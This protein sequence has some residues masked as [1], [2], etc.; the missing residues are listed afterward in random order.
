MHVLLVDD[1]DINLHLLTMFMKKAR[2]T[3][4][5]ASNGREA[6]DAYTAT[7]APA[8]SSSSS[9]LSSSP[10]SSSTGKRKFDYILMDISMPIMSGLESTKRIR[11]FEHAHGLLRCCVIALTG[12]A[13]TEAQ[14]EAETAGVDVFLPKPV[15]FAE[16]RRLLVVR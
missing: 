15:K 6:L 5:T 1:N 8:P 10:S 9:S 12:L 13:S 2:Y 16:L 3:Y 14:R 11:E 7:H 4:A